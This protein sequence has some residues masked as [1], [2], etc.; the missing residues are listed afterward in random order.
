MSDI[1]PPSTTTP[2]PGLL[3]DTDSL[4]CPGCGYDL[5]HLASDRC[6]ECG[7][8]IDTALAVS[9]IPWTHRHAIGSARAFFRTVVLASFRPAKLASAV[10]RPVDLIDARRFRRI[11]IVLAWL[12]LAAGFLAW[13]IYQNGAA[14][15][16]LVDDPPLDPSSPRE[17]TLRWE[18]A[19]T[20]S[21]G[22]TLWPVAPLVL[23]LVVTAWTKLQGYWFRPKD[24]SLVRQNRAVAVSVY[25]CA[26]LA[27]LPV[28]ATYVGA[29]AC[30]TLLPD[31]EKSAMFPIYAVLMT[32]GG[33]AL[34]L[35]PLTTWWTAI[36]LLAGTT[37]CQTS[38]LI[39]LAV[40]LPLAAVLSAAMIV[41]V[42]PVLIG[43]VWLMIDSRR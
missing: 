6:P 27:W 41:A 40:L 35:I 10:A 34:A 7:L 9:P 5:R 12:P 17:I 2:A 19:L 18:L 4:F 43:L 15:L 30:L 16:S 22:A 36:R 37:R 29:L 24:L 21:A 1:A 20:W 31:I 3:D 33:I 42:V 26:P 38:R 8:R 11:V 14:M 39:G 28:A 13:V 23:L 25:A 32:S